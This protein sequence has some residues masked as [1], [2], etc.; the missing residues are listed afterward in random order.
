MTTAVCIH[1]FIVDSPN[2]PKS[3]TR[4]CTTAG[5][6]SKRVTP[7]VPRQPTCSLWGTPAPNNTTERQCICRPV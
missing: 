7:Q 6:C 4:H 3:D 1:H 5:H 2:G